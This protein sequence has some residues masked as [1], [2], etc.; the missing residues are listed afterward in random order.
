MNNTKYP[1][2]LCDFIDPTDIEKLSGISLSYLHE[3]ALGDELTVTSAKVDGVY[4][5]K[6]FNKEGTLCLEAMLICK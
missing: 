4:Y 6:T 5:F 2:M 3:A 1:N